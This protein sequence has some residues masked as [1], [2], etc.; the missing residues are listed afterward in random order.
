V[1]KRLMLGA[2]ALATVGILA[3]FAT[4]AYATPDKTKSC[5]GCHSGITLAVTAT[6]TSNDGVTAAYTVSAPGA[7]AIAVFDGAT[8]L[9]TITGATGT[10]S[11]PVGKAYV[12]QAVAGPKETDG[13]GSKNINP[14]APVVVLTPDTTPVV[15]TTPTVDTTPVVTPDATGTAS[16][17][18]HVM[19]RHGRGVEGMTVTLTNTL[20]GAAVTGL[21]DSHGMVKFSNLTKG[22]YTASVTLADGTVLTKTFK[23]GNHNHRTVALKDHKAKTDHKSATHKIATHKI[24]KV[25]KTRTTHHVSAIRH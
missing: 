4:T 9:T 13:W 17:R 16:V 8:K 21:T 10:I 6:Q 5:D 1:K 22:T 3:A 2:V 18:I 14:V 24:A 12:I 25:A 20:T 7:S 23:V 19:A 11:V 15:T